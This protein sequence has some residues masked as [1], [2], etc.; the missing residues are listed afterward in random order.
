MGA[1]DPDYGLSTIPCGINFFHAHKFRSLAVIEF[2]DTIDIHPDQTEEYR[3]GGIEKRSTIES[4]LDTIYEGLAAVTQLSPDH[5]TLML[6][7]AKN[8]LQSL[9][10]KT[11][12]FSGF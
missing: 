1:C 8:A 7:Q 6:I 9:C 4:L 12:S 2:G 10:Q 11:I 5:D 3:A